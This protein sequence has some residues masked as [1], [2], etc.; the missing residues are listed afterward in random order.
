MFFSLPI[1]SEGSINITHYYN[2]ESSEGE[3]PRFELKLTVYDK[4]PQCAVA[5]LN[6]VEKSLELTFLMNGS[7]KF[8]IGQIELSRSISKVRGKYH[9]SVASFHG[10]WLFEF[11]RDFQTVN[12]YSGR[13]LESGKHS[14]DQKMEKGKKIK[15]VT[16]LKESFR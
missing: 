10:H 3:S 6:W 15:W 7:V 8:Y 2:Y 9:V 14:S 4:N 5:L 16:K 1:L 12:I 13:K 11:S